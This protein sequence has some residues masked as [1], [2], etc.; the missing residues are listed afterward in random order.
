MVRRSPHRNRA[1][2][3]VL[4]LLEHQFGHGALAARRRPHHRRRLSQPL[5]RE[6][7]QSGRGRRRAQRRQA[8]PHMPPVATRVVIARR[9][10]LALM[11][12]ADLHA[13]R[14]AAGGGAPVRMGHQRGG[15]RVHRGGGARV[16]PPVVRSLSRA[17]HARRPHRAR[18]LRSRRRPCAVA[19][20]AQA[21]RVTEDVA[22][23]VPQRPRRLRR[24]HSQLLLPERRGAPR[25]EGDAARVVRAVPRDHLDCDATRS[26]RE[27]TQR[28]HTARREVAIGVCA[29]QDGD[30]DEM[31]MGM[32]LATVRR[33]DGAFAISVACPEAL[34]KHA[35]CGVL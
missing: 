32:Q 15:T 19:A 5:R 24:P 9:R 29:D 33:C 26:G 2:A 6:W 8:R 13:T 25:V 20:A 22:G 1:V 4:L 28:K 12:R 10:L 14:L 34:Q 23:E 11:L 7:R 21:A 3:T 18:S 31:R 30:E 27:A 35:Q 17:A 16:S